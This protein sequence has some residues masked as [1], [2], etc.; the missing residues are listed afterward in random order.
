VPAIARRIEGRM[1]EV[2]AELFKAVFYRMPWHPVWTPWAGE[3]PTWAQSWIPPLLA[4]PVI[5]SA[6]H[7]A[8]PSE[9][10]EPLRAAT[11]GAWRH[12]VDRPYENR[13]L[14]KR[15]GARLP[16]VGSG[17]RKPPRRGKGM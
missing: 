13:G 1:A 2:G 11:R 3:G 12:P 6:L 8:E 5:P 17:R 15:A 10:R 16:A 4:L 9:K 7:T 14:F